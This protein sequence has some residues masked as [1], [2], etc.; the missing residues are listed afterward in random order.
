MVVHALPATPNTVRWGYFD[1]DLPPALTISSGDLVQVEA[2]THH[3][4]DAPDLLMDEGIRAVFDQV[5]DRGPGPHLLTGPI[6]VEGAEPG[7]T[8]E[9]RILNLEPR[10]AYGSNFAGHWGHLYQDFGKE[11]VTVYSIDSARALARAEFGYDWP[12]PASGDNPGAVV[13]PGSVP[14]VAALAG[15]AV[16]LRPHLGTIG[17]APAQPG[18]HSSVPPGDHGGNIDNWRIGAGATMHY[19]VLVAGAMLSVGDPH[20][21][22]GDGEI[23]G[24]ALESSLNGLLQI[25]VRRDLGFGYPVLETA[26]RW[27][28]HGFGD[29]LDEAMRQASLR[30][31]DLLGSRFGLSRDD[32]YS[33]MSVACDFTITQVVDQRQGVHAT[34]DKRLFV[35]N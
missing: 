18:R 32:A 3:A 27:T 30:L 19:P 25:F 2:I 5:V 7:D 35:G 13:A 22:Q 23:S 1:P 11:R 29:D 33:L 10:L 4:G 8:L 31:L 16:P 26:D 20:V 14:R 6:A 34:V 28:V 24:T 17:V 9:V 12:F 15:V 21:S